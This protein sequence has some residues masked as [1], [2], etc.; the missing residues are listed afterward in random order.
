MRA[1]VLAG[2]FLL[3]T[4]ASTTA[5]SD[6]SAAYW[7]WRYG[8][9]TGTMTMTT[10]APALTCPGNLQDERRVIRATYRLTFSGTSMRRTR[11]AA[12]ISYSLAAGGPAGNTEP[13]AMRTRRSSEEVVH[14]RTVTYD[15][16]DQPICKVEERPCTSSDTREF[17]RASNRLNVWMRRGGRVH[18]YAPQAMGFSTCAPDL[19]PNV[20]L[21]SVG[22]LFP[23]GLFNRSR[24][25]FRFSKTHQLARGTYIYRASIGVRRLPGTPRVRCKVC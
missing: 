9:V 11:P 3:L 5:A 19:A 21:P 25:T 17:R 8:P 6:R 15:N 1:V 22:K 2:A 7:G 24:A 18:L 12:D 10:S 16:F 23:V 14:V 13:I 4:A 20:L